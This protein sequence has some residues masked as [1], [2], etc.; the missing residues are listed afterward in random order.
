MA[1]K[2]LRKHIPREE[3]QREEAGGRPREHR[4]LAPPP[5][6]LAVGGGK[7]RSA[8]MESAAQTPAASSRVL[9]VPIF[10]YL[11]KAINRVLR[12]ASEVGEERT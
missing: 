2:Q 8:R 11:A 10:I 4:S 9:R 5:P 6:A 1:G 7:A 12:R 3:R